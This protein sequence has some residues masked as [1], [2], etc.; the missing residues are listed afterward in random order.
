MKS[1]IWAIIYEF[2]WKKP[3]QKYF[4]NTHL[5]LKKELSD[6]ENNKVKKSDK[7]PKIDREL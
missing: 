3:K 7:N 1:L 4:I 6:K 2:L 5:Q